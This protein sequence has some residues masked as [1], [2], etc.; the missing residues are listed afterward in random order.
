[1]GIQLNL[2]DELRRT[3]LVP[4]ADVVSVA[5]A[6]PL[7]RALLEAGLACLEV[8][9]RTPAAAE[10]IRAITAEVS[11][12]VVGAGT[13][14]SPEQADRAVEAGASFLVAPGLGRDVVSQAAQL[15]VPILPGVCTPTEIE[16]AAELGI[17]L[18]KFFPAE[19]AGGVPYL[20]AL[21]GPYGD[22][23]FVPSGGISPANVTSY[24]ELPTVVACGGSWMVRSSLIA[25]GDFAAITR[26]TAEALSVIVAGSRV[27]A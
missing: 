23:L 4:V 27:P 11:G 16:R 8:T 5:D 10:A 19:A 7:A 12:M 25:A 3:R 20:K 26:L 18:I 17:G 6:V 13:V 9:L 1:M 22:V 2:L 21:A 14:R 24:L 15:G